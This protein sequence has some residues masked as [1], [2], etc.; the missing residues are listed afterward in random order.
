LGSD[1]DLLTANA[2]SVHGV[3]RR[4]LL[5][6]TGTNLL[7]ELDGAFDV[8]MPFSPTLKPKLTQI[9][10]VSAGYVATTFEMLILARFAREG[11]LRDYEP[12][13]PARIR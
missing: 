4:P 13:L 11:F 7:I 2:H 5:D 3:L 8:L 1:H 10:G 9:A 12:T 6:P